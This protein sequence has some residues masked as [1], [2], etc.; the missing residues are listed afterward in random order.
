MATDFP[1]PFLTVLLSE[2]FFFA[3]TGLDTAFFTADFLA[4]GLVFP[5]LTVLLAGLDTTFLVGAGL[6]TAFF[7]ADFFAVT[8]LDTT[9]FSSFGSRFFCLLAGFFVVAG[10]ATAFFFS[11]GFLAAGLV[12]FPRDVAE[13]FFFA[14][15]RN[16]FS[17]G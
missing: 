14:V 7:T 16:R 2:T 17:G 1:F 5:A 12:D 3:G 6:A 13:S 8:G 9:F 15:I 10:L 4:A 11:A